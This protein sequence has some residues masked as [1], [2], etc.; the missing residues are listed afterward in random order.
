VTEGQ[1]WCPIEEDPIRAKRVE[2]GSRERGTDVV[3]RRT[4]VERQADQREP[5]RRVLRRRVEQ[6]DRGEC[7]VVHHATG[8]LSS[9]SPRDVSLDQAGSRP[10]ARRRTPGGASQSS[11]GRAPCQRTA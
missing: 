8:P 2:A 7:F 9:A 1:A 6:T 3:D 10:G 5:L 4:V 11:A